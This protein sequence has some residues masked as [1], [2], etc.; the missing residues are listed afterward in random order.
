METIS[1]EVDLPQGKGRV[2]ITLR[3]TGSVAFIVA[4]VRALFERDKPKDAYDIVWMIESWPGGPAEAAQ[5]FAARE[6][7]TAAE[8]GAALADLRT[9]F[10]TRDSIGPRSYA[11]FL[12]GAPDEEAILERRA[13]GAISEFLESLPVE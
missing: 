1:R 13:V 7:Y 2:S 6:A 12:A 10:S 4:K 11:R 3:V 8:V 5:A 9:A